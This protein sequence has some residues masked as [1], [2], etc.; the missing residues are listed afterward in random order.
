[1]TRTITIHPFTGG[2]VVADFIHGPEEPFAGQEAFFLDTS[3]DP[4]GLPIVDWQWSFDDGGTATGN[5]PSH[6]FATVGEHDV[7]LTVTTEDGRTASTTKSV[8]V[9]TPPDPI[10]GFGYFPQPVTTAIPVTFFDQSSDPIGRPVVAWS[11]SFGDGSTS[12]DPSPSHRFVAAGDYTVELTITTDDGRSATTSQ[13]GLASPSHRIR[14]PASAGTHSTPR[15]STRFSSLPAASTRP[16][17]RSSRG[18]GPSATA[19]PRAQPNPTHRFAANGTY[20]VTLVVTT[21]DGR[22]GASDE[23]GD[24]RD[25]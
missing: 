3:S 13:V 14:S 12:T 21:E 8:T 18:S 17:P 20:D 25:A 19:R 10:A 1:M 15:S 11:W 9:L 5:N 7:S 24:R 2:P 22:I 16:E 6:A 4:A 23:L